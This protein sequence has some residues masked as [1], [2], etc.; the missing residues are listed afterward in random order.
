MFAVLFALQID[1]I[2]LAR[3]LRSFHLIRAAVIKNDSVPAVAGALHR[4]RRP[5]NHCRLWALM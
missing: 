1:N 5:A 3:T 2:D 4:K